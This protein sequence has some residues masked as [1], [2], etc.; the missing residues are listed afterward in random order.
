MVRVVVTGRD[1]RKAKENLNYEVNST[2]SQGYTAEGIGI[3]TTSRWKLLFCKICAFLFP[4]TS[5]MCLLIWPWKHRFEYCL[6][7]KC[8]V[9]IFY[10]HVVFCSR[11]WFLYI[12]AMYPLWWNLKMAWSCK[13]GQ[14]VCIICWNKQISSVMV[15]L[16][17]KYP[18]KNPSV[19]MTSA[20]RGSEVLLLSFLHALWR[21]AGWSQLNIARK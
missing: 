7:S 16:G 1:W 2:F 13:K 14:Q 17:I 18:T 10:L 4:I 8:S 15:I 9:Y 20:S 12:L 5:Q 11:V 21:R 6:V 3:N 19:L